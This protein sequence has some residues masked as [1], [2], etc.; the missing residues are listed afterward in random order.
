MKKNISK[1]KTNVNSEFNALKKI[2]FEFVPPQD[3]FSYQPDS[4]SSIGGKRGRQE[5]GI[6]SVYDA[7]GRDAQAEERKAKKSDEDPY[8]PV[9]GESQWSQKQRL[10]EGDRDDTSK[11]FHKTKKQNKTTHTNKIVRK[12]AT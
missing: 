4:G 11:I 12:R 6:K 7:E 9:P 5:Y 8:S 2:G 3:E 10:P 1:T